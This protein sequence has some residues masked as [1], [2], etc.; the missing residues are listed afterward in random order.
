LKITWEDVNFE[1][2]SRTTFQGSEEKH[3]VRYPDYYV[4]ELTA[5]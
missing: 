2:I 1:V 3:F 4:Y 5:K